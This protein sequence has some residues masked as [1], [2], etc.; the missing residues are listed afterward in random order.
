MAPSTLRGLRAAVGFFVVAGLLD[1]L[2]VV[3]GS[4]PLTVETAWE[5]LGRAGLDGLLAMGLWRRIPLCRSVAMIYCLAALITD[6]VVV[7]WALAQA[8]VRFPPRILIQAAYEVPCCVLLLPYLR[9][10]EAS[11]LFARPSA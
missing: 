8:P 9:S 7:S 6:A 5:A 1:I 3:L 2:L 10:K 4:R 11:L